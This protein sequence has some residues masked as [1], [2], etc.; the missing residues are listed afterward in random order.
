MKRLSLL[1]LLLPFVLGQSYNGLAYLD[2]SATRGVGNLYTYIELEID[3]DVTNIATATD[4][5][6][7]WDYSARFQVPEGTD[8]FGGGTT[9]TEC[10]TIPSAGIYD[11]HVSLDWD[12]VSTSG[13]VRAVL[14]LDAGCD[15][16]AVTFVAGAPTGAS[17]WPNARTKSAHASQ[18]Q[19]E[20]FG[21]LSLSAGDE[22]TLVITQSGGTSNISLQDTAWTYLRV[23]KR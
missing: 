7:A 20:V 15:Q 10:I 21:G 18:R 1:L 3:G 6:P 8:W 2:A 12:V 17:A 16:T 11:V 13:P 22:L 14:A 19:F 23:F 9:D 4:T 5:Y